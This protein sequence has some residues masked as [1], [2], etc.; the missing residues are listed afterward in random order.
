[1][2]VNIQPQD[3]NAQTVFFQEGYSDMA[4]LS[5]PVGF[6]SYFSDGKNGNQTNFVTNVLSITQDIMRG[7]AT[8]SKI[9]QRENIQGWDIGDETENLKSERFQNKTRVFPIMQEFA[10]VSHSETLLFRGFNQSPIDPSTELIQIRRKKIHEGLGEGLDRM[11]RKNELICSEAIR[12]GRQ[13]L[14]DGQFYDYDRSSTNAFAAALVWTDPNALIIEEID[15]I[16][17]RAQENGKADPD[18]AIAG[19]DGYAALLKQPT[20]AALAD[21]RRYSVV[22]AGKNEILPPL[23]PNLQW[24]VTAGFKYQAHIHTYK[25]RDLPIFTYNEKYQDAA[26]D[27]QPYMPV[28]EFLVGFSGARCDRSFGPRLTFEGNLTQ[29]RQVNELLGFESF[30]TPMPSNVKSP[31]AFDPRM[32]HVDG[33]VNGN[34]D[35]ISMRLTSGGIY[36][37]VRTDSF[38][39]I[40]GIS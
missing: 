30:T 28:D 18:H 2:T 25:G 6:Q 29:E 19:A 20:V 22:V 36:T 23:P 14:D 3:L 31:A 34:N 24:M 39:L 9:F 1:M 35:V 40:T 11:M 10:S 26:K 7:E 33:K 16:C 5:V 21:N 12:L 4:D 15:D 38:G 37:P 17:D 13:T 27:W 32:F 8:I